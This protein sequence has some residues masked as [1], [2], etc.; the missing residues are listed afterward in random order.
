MNEKLTVKRGG[1]LLGAALV[2][3]GALSFLGSTREEAKASVVPATST[4][5]APANGIQP[6]SARA[7]ADTLDMQLD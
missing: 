4:H 2:V 7:E 1:W 3:M 5:A 6:G